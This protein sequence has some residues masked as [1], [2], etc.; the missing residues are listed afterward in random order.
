MADSDRMDNLIKPA[1]IAPIIVSAII[2]AIFIV[3]GIYY[4]HHTIIRD[5]QPE[6]PTN[7][8]VFQIEQA[9]YE[10]SSVTISGWF[11]RQNADTA[12]AS[13]LPKMRLILAKQGE[14]EEK[15]RYLKADYGQPRPEVNDYFTNGYD[16]TNCGFTCRIPADRISPEECYEIVI[17][18]DQ[19]RAEAY[20][21]GISLYQSELYHMDPDVYQLLDV[22]GT[23]L[24]Q[25]VNQGILHVCR[26]DIGIYVYQYEHKLY[27]IAEDF[28]KINEGWDYTQYQ[29]GTTRPEKLPGD[30]YAQGYTYDNQGWSFTTTE[31]TSQIDCGK[32]RVSVRDIPESYPVTFI[33][34]GYYQNGLWIWYNKFFPDYE[35][36]KEG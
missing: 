22:A 10:G 5:A 13:S 36:L 3:S 14:S 16:Y 26:P 2:L 32:Y 24:E 8:V 11:F 33:E 31:I 30:K 19:N 17:Q 6:E 18:P 9:E 29:L 20:R 15:L 21:S 1:R 27:W 7:D 12:D 25:I 4:Y 23:D 34:T 28:Y 35:F